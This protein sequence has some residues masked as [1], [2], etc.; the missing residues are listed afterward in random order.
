MSKRSLSEAALIKEAIIPHFWAVF[1]FFLT[2]PP[3]N[4]T[5]DAA[6]IPK[7]LTFY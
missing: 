6:F 1:P 3:H 2:T 7:Y 5:E 4:N